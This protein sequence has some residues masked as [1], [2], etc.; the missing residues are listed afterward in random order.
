MLVSVSDTE[1]PSSLTWLD[2]SARSTVMPFGESLW[3]IRS[4]NTCATNNCVIAAR[5]PEAGHL[6]VLPIES[7][8]IK[9]EPRT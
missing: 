9:L 2:A 5:T 3:S 8:V 7:I 4:I 1:A 6:V